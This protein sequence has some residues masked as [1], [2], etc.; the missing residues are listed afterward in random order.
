MAHLIGYKFNTYSIYILLGMVTLLLSMVT[1]QDLALAP[2]PEMDAGN[3]VR[4]PISDALVFYPIL[5][6][7]LFAFLFRWIQRVA[8]SVTIVS[9]VN[10]VR[11]MDPLSSSSWR[12]FS[13]EACNMSLYVC[14]ITKYVLCWLGLMS[15]YLTNKMTYFA[16]YSRSWI[17]LYCNICKKNIYRIWDIYSNG[18]MMISF[19]V[20]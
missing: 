8:I 9:F 6:F 10:I 5:F 11:W 20:L 18:N 12:E 19:F 4:L 2:L 1:A 16:I 13:F 15:I 17:S 7:S 14:V 3:G